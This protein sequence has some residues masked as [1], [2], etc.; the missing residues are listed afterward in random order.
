VSGMEL[1]NKTVPEVTLKKVE[2][3][4]YKGKHLVF[5]VK[6]SRMNYLVEAV[7]NNDVVNDGERFT[8]VPR[9]LW[10]HPRK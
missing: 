10:R 4:W 6:K 9:L 3:R 8:T 7:G 1:M 2:T 5:I